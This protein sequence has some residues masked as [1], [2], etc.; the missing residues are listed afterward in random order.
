MGAWLAYT[1]YT[2]IGFV[3]HMDHG[4]LEIRYNAWS[5]RIAMTSV[6]STLKWACR[7]TRKLVSHEPSSALFSTSIHTSSTCQHSFEH[8]QKDC[9]SFSSWIHSQQ[10]TSL[11]RT[12]KSPTTTKEDQKTVYPSSSSMAGRISRSRGSTSSRT[13]L[14]GESTV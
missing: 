5:W 13:S 3:I 11:T 1:L 2:A 9:T 7:G 12:A 10:A 8:Q 4:T 6:S 14:L